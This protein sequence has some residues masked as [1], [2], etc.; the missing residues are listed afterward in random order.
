[1]ETLE[2][3]RQGIAAQCAYAV[4]LTRGEHPEV[5]ERALQE[6]EEAARE[7]EERHAQKSA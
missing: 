5:L 3:E 4:A 6:N 7:L 1:V 2:A